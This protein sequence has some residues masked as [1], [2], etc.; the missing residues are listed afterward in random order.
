MKKHD[1]NLQD[2]IIMIFS[3]LYEDELKKAWKMKWEH[4]LDKK[5]SKNTFKKL[6]QQKKKFLKND[7]INIKTN[8]KFFL[9]IKQV[10][11]KKNKK[12]SK[13]NKKNAKKLNKIKLIN[14]F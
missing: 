7:F 12:K 2:L 3:K 1:I 8:R 10:I 6:N 4:N 11:K 9:I 5:I 14:L 13:K